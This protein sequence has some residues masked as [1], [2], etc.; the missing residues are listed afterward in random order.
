[1]GWRA[2]TLNTV[3][4]VVAIVVGTTT[5]LGV[6]GKF[7]IVHPMKAF[8]VKMTYPIQPNANGGKSLAD[9]ATTV[10]AIDVKVGNVET[11]LSKVDDR[12]IH[13]IEQHNK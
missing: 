6:I 1:M 13:H 12:L 8:I 10:T 9:V 4:Q 11:W 5:F 2:M 7:L 3:A